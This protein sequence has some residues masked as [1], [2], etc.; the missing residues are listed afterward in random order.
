MMQ[1]AVEKIRKEQSDANGLDSK[2]KAMAGAVA[3]KLCDFC[4][5]DVTFSEAVVHGGTLSECM[6][7]VANGVGNSISDIEA[8]TKAVRFYFPTAKIDVTMT[9]NLI[10]GTAE[11]STP[12]RGVVLDLMDF[13]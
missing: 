2:A 5:Q 3:D 1:E 12:K 6:A 7:A 4:Q 13:M 8:Y 9:I 11:T 10:G